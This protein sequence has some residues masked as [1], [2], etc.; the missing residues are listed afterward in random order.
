MST[1]THTHQEDF[2]TSQERMFA[3]LVTPSS[4]RKWWHA[5]RAIVMPKEGGTW[6]AAWGDDE[7]EPDFITVATIREFKPPHRLVL[8]DYRYHSKTGPLGFDAEFVTEFTVA[9][10]SAGASL[11]VTQDGFPSD[12]EADEFFRACK[13]GWEDTFAGIRK[14]LEESGNA[15]S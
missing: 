4:I 5:A 1:R 6:A 10:T 7:D 3:I 13:Q 14:F 15:A 9:S 8:S 12:P 11:Q 2:A